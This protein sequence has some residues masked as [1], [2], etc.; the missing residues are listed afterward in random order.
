MFLMAK[1]LRNKR[2]SV[3][4]ELALVIPVLILFLA[5]M[6]ELSR[7][8]YLQNTLDYA[9]KESARIGSS[10]RESVDGNFMSRGTLPRQKMENLIRNSVRIMGVIEEPG[11]FTIKYLNPGG[12][13]I[14]G[15][16]NDLPFNRQNNPGA[17]DYVV[18]EIT[19]PGSSPSVNAPIPVVFNPGNIFQ[20]S[21]TLMSRAVFKIE[22]RFER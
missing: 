17:I 19:Y 7:V 22:G 2:G 21:V 5:G 4:A 9:A 16:Q 10:V 11:Q 6:F 3:F 18:V 1:N 20:N 15:I 14:M 8:F 13:E 12:N